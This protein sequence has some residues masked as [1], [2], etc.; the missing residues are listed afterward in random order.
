[1]L[2]LFESQANSF[3]LLRSLGATPFIRPR[4]VVISCWLAEL[5]PR[6]S[7]ARQR[8]YRFIYRAVD[9]IIYFSRNQAVIYRD[10]L[11]V[12]DD[13]LA[14]IP[15]GVDHQYFSPRDDVR[16]DIDVLAVGRD[17]GRDWATLFAAV[18][19]SS[20]T[21]KVACRPDDLGGLSVPPNV[22]ILGMVERSAYRDL[23]ARAR[24]VVVPTRALAYPSG[25]S[26]LLESMAMAKC[27][28]V[29]DTPAIQD[30]VVDGRTGL[31]AP[32]HSPGDLRRAIERATSDPSLRRRLGVSARTAV[33]SEF[34]VDVMWAGVAKVLSGL[35]VHS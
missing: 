30:Y 8:L 4:L 17:R 20:L 34:N 21:V 11:G 12:S 29:T 14:Y 25:Q 32:A 16:E 1:V 7:P 18:R 22:E 26:V 24:V 2:A 9:R 15:F 35:G 19:G 6:F 5:M 13:R 3:A 23:T 10:Q 33:E 27:C 31:L 28:V